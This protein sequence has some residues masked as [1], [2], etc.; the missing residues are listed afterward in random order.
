[1]SITSRLLAEIGP[2]A[3]KATVQ[4]VR[5]G[6]FWVAVMVSVDGH[7]KCG[8]ASALRGSDHHQDSQLPVRNAG[9]L[10][11]SSA[12]ALAQ[13][14]HSPSLLEAS[15]GMATINALLQVDESAIVELNASEAIARRGEGKNVAVIGHFPF[16]SRLQERVN[17]VW[18][19]EQRPGPDD[20][21]ATDAPHLIPQADVV[22]ITSTALINGTLDGLLG[23][24]R[25]DAYVLLLGPSTPMA[26]LVFEFG[27]HV[28]SGT[29]VVDDEIVLRR[30][31][32][33]A[34]FRQIHRQGVR[35][36]TMAAPQ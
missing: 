4:D 35:L 20:R 27:V 8:L 9:S 23:L 21:P 34:T 19:L 17:K 3:T 36:V 12:C 18:V 30:V 26:P 7:I 29:L 16:I 28:L 2:R 6:A 25:P 32:E 15:V 10:A 22:A 11:G 24:C 13:L 33:G 5:I 14:I 31:S 1:M